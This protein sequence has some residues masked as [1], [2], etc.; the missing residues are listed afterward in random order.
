MSLDP[1]HHEKRFERD[2]PTYLPIIP[3]EYERLL[4][5]GW[6]KKTGHPKPNPKR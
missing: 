3:E 4:E 6:D 2:I 1:L 5:F